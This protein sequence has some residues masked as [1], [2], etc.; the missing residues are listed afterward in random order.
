MRITLIDR[1][2]TTSRIGAALAAEGHE[3]LEDCLPDPGTQQACRGLS[4]HSCPLEAGVDLALTSIER[5]G[6][7]ASAGTVCARRAG[8][9][10]VTVGRHDVH[11]P[12][13]GGALTRAALRGDE[14]V[15][16]TAGEALERALADVGAAAGTVDVHRV[17]DRERIV[18]TVDADLTAKDRGRIAVRVLDALTASGRGAIR[19]DVV[20]RRA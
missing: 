8:V 14:L 3:V 19:R 16:W 13:L 5:D 20:V 10:V 1:S 12:D 7:T 4:H 9:P 11:H 2:E 18:V 6:E 17:A 15:R